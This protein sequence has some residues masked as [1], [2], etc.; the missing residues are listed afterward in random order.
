MGK[1]PE[2]LCY[3]GYVSHGDVIDFKTIDRDFKVTHVDGNVERHDTASGGRADPKLQ[4]RRWDKKANSVQS[5]GAKGELVS[6]LC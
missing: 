3:H 1:A 6:L 4:L 2:T 5:A